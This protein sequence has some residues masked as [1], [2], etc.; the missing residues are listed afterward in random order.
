MKP[1]ENDTETAIQSRVA[2]VFD[3]APFVQ[4]LEIRLE[5]VGPGRCRA[6]MT[7]SDKHLQ[8]L[9]RAHGAAVTALAGQTALGAATSIL[10]GEEQVVSPEFK[11]NLFRPA[12]SGLLKCEAKVIKSGR[13]LV[14]VESDVRS[15]EPEEEKLVAKGSFT[16]TRLEEHAG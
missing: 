2:R 4:L 3:E 12:Y 14:F 11:M 6:A 13:R 5:E 15:G 1:D 9:G 16:F 7:V 10:S 8:H